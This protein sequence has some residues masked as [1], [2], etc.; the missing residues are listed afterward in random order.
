M[1]MQDIINKIKNFEDASKDF[2]ISKFLN[3]NIYGLRREDHDFKFK[4]D[5][6]DD[7]LSDAKTILTINETYLE[8]VTVYKMQI[9]I[10]RVKK[11]YKSEFKNEIKE[12][13]EIFMPPK[14]P[15]MPYGKEI[16]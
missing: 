15:F 6:I 8:S 7:A 3:I 14:L 5:N 9:K 13:P 2:I 4:Y 10:S 16:K 11:F 12:K 1:N